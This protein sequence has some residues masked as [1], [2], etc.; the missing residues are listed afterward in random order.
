MF[1]G[2]KQ[3]KIRK[4]ASGH[5]TVILT[6]AFDHPELISAQIELI[7]RTCRGGYVHMIAD[8]SPDR[9]VRAEIKH[10]VE[11]F[12]DPQFIYYSLPLEQVYDSS[13]SHGTALNYVYDH[14]ISSLDDA[15]Y[16]L[17]IDHDIFPF[18]E[19]SVKE[20]LGEQD[21]YGLPQT[22][23]EKWYLWPGFSAWR[24]DRVRPDFMP[25][26][27]L[28]TGGGSYERIFKDLSMSDHD[29]ATERYVDIYDHIVERSD[30]KDIERTPQNSIVSVIGDSWVHLIDGGDRDGT[31][32]RG[33]KLDYVL[34]RIRSGSAVKEWAE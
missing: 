18:K 17:T 32:L 13:R 9:S 25:V 12:S 22:R 31:G 14:I 21:F 28:D 16:L 11:A 6:I 10:A 34:D 20:M 26:P 4:K 15:V 30:K 29:L 24:I 33:Y 8:N 19:F 2:L 23:E 7:K 3:G 5:D 27:G 1:E